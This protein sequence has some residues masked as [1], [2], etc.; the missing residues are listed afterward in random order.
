MRRE[1]FLLQQT[2]GPVL[3]FV[4][5][6]FFLSFYDLIE[7]SSGDDIIAFFIFQ[8]KDFGQQAAL[9]QFSFSFV[10][11][12]QVKVKKDQLPGTASYGNPGFQNT[13]FQITG[14]HRPGERFGK[15]QPPG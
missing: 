15:G 6:I 10:I 8:G 4:E 13:P 7:I 9:G 3:A 2:G 14:L 1:K 12:F 5:R 11:G